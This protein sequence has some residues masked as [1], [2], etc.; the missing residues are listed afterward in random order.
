MGRGPKLKSRG[1]ASMMVNPEAME[2]PTVDF[3][4]PCVS[5]PKGRMMDCVSTTGHGNL[6]TQR[7][8]FLS[9]SHLMVYLPVN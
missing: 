8:D 9:N 1:V 2:Q 5:Y 6:A 4:L 3:P 7:F